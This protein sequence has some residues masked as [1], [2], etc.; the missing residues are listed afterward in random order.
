MAASAGHAVAYM[1]G[2]IFKHIIACEQL[3]FTNGFKNIVLLAVNCPR[4]VGVI[5]IF[6]DT[7]QIIAQRCQIIAPRWL[8]DI[9]SA[10]DTAIFKNR[11][12]NIKYS[13]GCVARNAILLKP[14]VANILVFNFCEQKFVQHGPI[15]IGPIGC[16]GFFFLSH[17]RR[18]MAQLCLWTKIRTKQWLVLGASA[19]KCMRAG[20]LC[21]KCDNFACLHIWQDQNELHLQR[22]FFFCQKSVS[23]FSK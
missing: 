6:D 18:K 15:T 8:N 20:L 1:V 23:W 11:S 22:W 14:N 2:S 13:C 12:Q 9:R 10:A 5:L 7:T 4:L 16:N 3:Y 21:P 17:F 19:F